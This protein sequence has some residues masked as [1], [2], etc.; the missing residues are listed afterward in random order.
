MDARVNEDRAGGA[1]TQTAPGADLGPWR[2][3]F[4]LGRSPEAAMVFQLVLNFV[5]QEDKLKT[6][7]VTVERLVHLKQ[8]QAHQ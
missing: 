8:R 7:P 5:F 4:Q 6:T 2:Q 3:A 1:W